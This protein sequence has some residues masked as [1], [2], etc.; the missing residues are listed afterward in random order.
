MSNLPKEWTVPL[1]SLGFAKQR[2]NFARLRDDV[3]QTIFVKKNLYKPTFQIWAT[4]G[5]K[6]PYERRDGHEWKYVFDGYVCP[7]ALRFFAVNESWWLKEQLPRAIDAIRAYALPWLDSHFT[8][9][10]VLVDVEECLARNQSYNYYFEKLPDVRR[11]GHGNF[12]H[13]ASLL[14]LKLGD[15]KASCKRAYEWLHVIRTNKNDEEPGRTIRQMQDMGCE[16]NALIESLLAK[17]I[18]A[19]EPVVARPLGEEFFKRLRGEGK[20]IKPDLPS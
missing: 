18:P 13:L 1:K 3:Q 5:I 7:N 2:L 20:K 15:R 12:Y 9:Q 6:D 19:P 16:E 8:P 14:H 10:E 11:Q 17:P 4:I